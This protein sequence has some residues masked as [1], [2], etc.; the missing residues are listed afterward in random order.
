V[1]GALATAAVAG[2]AGKRIENGVFFSPKGY[3][4]AVPAG[5]W[6]VAGDTRADLELRRAGA[7]MLVNA[8][9]DDVP[10]AGLAVLE[11]HLLVGL[12]DRTVVV[13][14]EVSVNGMRGRH[15]VLEG[16]AAA[17]GPPVKVE[18]YVMRD[19]RCVYDLVYAAPPAE[20]DRGRAAF[21]HLVETFVTE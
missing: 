14:E 10:R 15:A 17:G 3:R 11:R 18:L 2:C 21:S 19:G 4:V 6:T 9:C 8:A 16:R 1:A 5:G 12:R 13:E 7:G 20:F